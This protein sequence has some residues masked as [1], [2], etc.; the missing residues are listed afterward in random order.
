MEVLRR[1]AVQHHNEMTHALGEIRRGKLVSFGHLLIERRKSRGKSSSL[2][3]TQNC[4]S[5]IS[6]IFNTSSDGNA[7][8]C[9]SSVAKELVSIPNLSTALILCMKRDLRDGRSPR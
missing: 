9:F 6:H 7:V 2:V 1:S 3:L 4:K 5:Y 8:G